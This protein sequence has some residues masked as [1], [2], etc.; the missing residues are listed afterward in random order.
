MI[1]NKEAQELRKREDGY[2]G[3]VFFFCDVLRLENLGWR[4]DID[5]SY[6]VMCI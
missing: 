1:N 6:P 4:S 2:C 5:F 3:D